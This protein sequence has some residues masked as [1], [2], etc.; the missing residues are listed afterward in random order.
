MTEV[1]N[2]LGI[3]R[4]AVRL[5]KNQLRKE[6]LKGLLKKKNWETIETKSAEKESTEKDYQKITGK[7]GIYK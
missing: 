6:G 3:T 1:C 4:E 2:V 5:W 7:P